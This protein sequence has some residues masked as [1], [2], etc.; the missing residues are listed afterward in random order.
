MAQI[1]KITNPDV[2]RYLTSKLQFYLK[3]GVFTKVVRPDGTE[4]VLHV[5]DA[6]AGL[7]NGELYEVEDCQ[8]CQYTREGRTLPDGTIE[9]TSKQVCETYKLG[10]K[11]HC[12]CKFYE[13]SV[14]LLQL[15]ERLT[16]RF[17]RQATK[18]ELKKAALNY[19]LNVK[20]AHPL[21]TIN[22]RD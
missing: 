1:A 3:R 17:G 9:Y 7:L 16:S 19:M 18:E 6:I 11:N 10:D 21:G 12:G 14:S 15:V 2:K 8:A 5:K 22:T 13:H 20:K 4:M